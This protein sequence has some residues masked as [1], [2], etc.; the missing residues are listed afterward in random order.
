[1]IETLLGMLAERLRAAGLVVAVDGM[2]LIARNVREPEGVTRAGKAL[3][4]GLNQEV[5]CQR[6]T[7]GE[8]WWF[9]AWSGAIRGAPPELEPLCPAVE[10]M[11][12]AERIAHVLAVP[13]LS[14]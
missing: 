9:W 5:R 10:V 7:S 8:L 12:A 13:P 2:A 3:H 1:M 11:R 4:P 14:E 6:R